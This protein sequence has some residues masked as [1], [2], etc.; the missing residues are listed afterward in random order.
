MKSNFSYKTAELE[1]TYDDIENEVR[2]RISRDYGFTIDSYKLTLNWATEESTVY[3]EYTKFPKYKAIDLNRLIVSN[4][5]A[6]ELEKD[7][8]NNHYENLEKTIVNALE[9]YYEV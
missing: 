9:N 3:V 2:R 5:L 4:K 8:E 7:K 1:V 6:T